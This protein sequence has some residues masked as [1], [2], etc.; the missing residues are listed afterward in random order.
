MATSAKLSLL[1][2]KRLLVLPRPREAV[3]RGEKLKYYQLLR[4]QHALL[5]EGTSPSLYSHSLPL[6]LSFYSPMPLPE[7]SAPQP[8]PALMEAEMITGDRQKLNESGEMR[9]KAGN[10]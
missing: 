9:E 4:P 7:I 8:F 6:S 3:V 2:G 1:Q 10:V 5:A